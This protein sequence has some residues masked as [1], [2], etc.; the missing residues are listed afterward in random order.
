MGRKRK[1]RPIHGWLVIDKP[2]G[3]TSAAVVGKVRRLTGAARVGH[4]GTL[5]PMATGVLPL[6][7]GEAT[8]TVAYT[9][10]A[11]KVYRFGL[12]WGERRDTDDAEGAIT[13]TSDV[14]PAEDAIVAA[15]D[16]FTGVIE[17]VPPA[18]SAVKVDGRRAYDL[19][20]E[21][22]P[23]DLAPRRVVIHAFTYLGAPDADHA[24][25]EVRCGKGTYMRSLARDLAAHLGTVGHV[26]WLR[27][28]AVGPF[29]V[30]HAISLEKLAAFMHSAADFEGL[31]PVET[32]LDDIPALALTGSEAGRLRCGQP[33]E[34]LRTADKTRV[35]E[36]PDGTIL[37]AKEGDRPV[38]LAEL[39][40]HDSF[41]GWQI[42]PVRV[43]N[44]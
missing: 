20:R 29:A 25:F 17:Q 28:L 11:T 44:L 2:S 38:A 19:A 36:L 16:A 43:L 10:A 32:A 12:R 8:K 27:R 6:A 26:A 40:A 23:V 35:R 15:L 3:M 1:G 34:V 31:L 41:E 30:E 9:M 14:R 37:F 13:E 33:V 4:A 7:F 24:E 5:D 39:V 42:R 21:N 22:R 18:Y